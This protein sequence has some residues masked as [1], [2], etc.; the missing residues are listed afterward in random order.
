MALDIGENEF[1]EKVLNASSTVP[2]LVDF[3]APWCGPCK[4]LSPVLEKLER[5]MNGRFTL[6]KINTDESQ[7]LAGAFQITGIPAVKL[8]M[9]GRVKDEFTGALGEVQVRKFLEKN[10][11]DPALESILAIED[12]L[13]AAEEILK[14]GRISEELE[15]ILLDAFRSQGASQASFRYLEAIRSTG[16]PY[17]DARNQILEFLKEAEQEE[18]DHFLKIAESKTTDSLDYFIEKVR[19]SQG[20]I[21]D[22]YKKGLL[23][24]F[25]LLGNDPLVPEY[26]RKLSSILF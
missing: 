19:S 7:A 13:K 5:E 17:S 12:P 26:R 22:R 24:A 1:E 21:R 11:P 20:K 15:K 9:N 14:S 25:A 8:F 6:V 18:K 16:S 23:A 10:L 3:W 2:I 4:M